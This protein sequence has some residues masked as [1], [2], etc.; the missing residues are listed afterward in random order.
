MKIRNPACCT[1]GN[2]SLQERLEKYI[3][4]PY[5]DG[6]MEGEVVDW[7]EVNDELHSEW[8]EPRPSVCTCGGVSLEQRLK[9]A[10]MC[11]RHDQKLYDEISAFIASS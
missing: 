7:I 9:D 10:N 5:H 4:C 11:P 3:E 2:I 1:C 8:V 6:E